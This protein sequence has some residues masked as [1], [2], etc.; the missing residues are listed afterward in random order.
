ML[1]DVEADLVDLDSMVPVSEAR[2][3]LG[4]ERC[5]AGNI[6][7][8][9]AVRNGTPQSIEKGLEECFRD[10]GSAAYA[11]AGGCEIPRDTPAENLRAMGRFAQAHR[12]MK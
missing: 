6:D 8:V 9:R 1:K 10:A 12:P 2:K 7:P 11:V 5:L 4:A 3:K